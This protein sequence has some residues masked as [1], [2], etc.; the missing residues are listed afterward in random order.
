MCVG[1]YTEKRQKASEAD[2]QNVPSVMND[3]MLVGVFFQF[4]SSN[5]QG[6]GSILAE[7]LVCGLSSGQ[8]VRLTR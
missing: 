3:D 7:F 1:I 2:Q 5:K 6:T 8:L 4:G